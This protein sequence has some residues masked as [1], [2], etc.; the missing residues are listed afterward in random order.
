M[1]EEPIQNQILPPEEPFP[2]VPNLAMPKADFAVRIQRARLEA[3]L[4]VA[5]A[6]AKAHCSGTAIR[7]IENRDFSCIDDNPFHFLNLIERLG[8]TYELTD[9]EILLIKEDFKTE[10]QSYLASSGKSSETS[11]Q[12]TYLDNDSHLHSRQKTSALLITTL[13]VLLAL[14]VAGGYSYKRY[15]RARLQH[16]AQ[17]YDLPSLLETP[18]LPMD[19]MPIPNS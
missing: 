15:Q 1:E 3:N 18:R 17:D 9:D 4:S 11:T 13:I 2:N 10:L 14:L 8:H 7:Q 5:D 19:V 12:P 16:A 6:A